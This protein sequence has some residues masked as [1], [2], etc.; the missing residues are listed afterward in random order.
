[1]NPALEPHY[2]VPQIVAMWGYSDDYIRGV[3]RH[4]PGV[5][6]T[7][8]RKHTTLPVPES[9]M[10]RVHR[11]LAVAARPPWGRSAK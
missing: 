4:V 5:L 8:L 11:E 7:Q 1:M 10:V 2:T 3:F 6:Q 9:V